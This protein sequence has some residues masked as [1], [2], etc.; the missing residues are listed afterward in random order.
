MSIKYLGTGRTF[1]AN[2]ILYSIACPHCSKET[3][4][5][6]AITGNKITTQLALKT[7]EFIDKPSQSFQGRKVT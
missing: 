4:L 7:G 2:S 3:I 6:V 5:E 1:Q